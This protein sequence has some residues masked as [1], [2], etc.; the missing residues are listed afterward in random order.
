MQASG[1]RMP[2]R[3]RLIRPGGTP[4]RAAIVACSCSSPRNATLSPLS[5]SSN[6]PVIRSPPIPGCF[7]IRTTKEIA[8]ASASSPVARSAAAATELLSHGAVS[9]QRSGSLGHT[10]GNLPEHLT[11]LPIHSRR[12]GWLTQASQ[13]SHNKKR[14]PSWRSRP[15]LPAGRSGY[16]QSE[17]PRA[18]SPAAVP[19]SVA[20]SPV[21]C[22]SSSQAERRWSKAWLN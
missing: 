21:A 6:H 8:T 9:V 3:H 5:T 22:S 19:P 4:A 10:P 1:W 2:S 11:L 16:S 7:Q 14:A 15:R 20:S 18:V 17:A 13:D 12:H